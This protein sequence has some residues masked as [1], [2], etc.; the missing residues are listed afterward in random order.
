MWFANLRIVL[1][2]RTIERGALEIRD[3][4][5][6]AIV[7][8]YQN[9]DIDGAGLT[10]IPGIIDL[11]G[12]MIERDM[13]P[14][15][16]VL[17]PIE[18]ALFELDKRLAGNG[19]TTA[20][21]AIS[22]LERA[23]RIAPSVRSIDRAEQIILTIRNLRACLLTDFRVH[24]RFEV[25]CPRA[26]PTVI[27][28]IRRGHV[29]FVSL[30]DHTPGQGQYRD[31]TKYAEVIEKWRRVS[32][33]EAEQMSLDRIRR[34]EEN[35]AS[36]EDARPVAQAALDHHLLVASHDDDT[37]SKVLT[38]AQL[39]VTLC[40]FPVTIEAARQA[41][42]I[43]MLVAMGAPNI[44]LGCSHTGNLSAREAIDAGLVDVLVADYYPA[45]LLQAAF[46]LARD[47]AMPLHQ[48]IRLITENPA[49]ALHLEGRGRLAVGAVAD[50]A[51]VE[52]G[53]LP[54]VRGT[55]RAGVPTYWDGTM[56][57][58]E[59][60]AGWRRSLVESARR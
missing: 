19:I 46:A 48:A 29:G 34:S 54:R 5:I 52:D 39:G 12:D 55:L 42:E 28:L 35:R 13:E 36:W 17:F 50:I 49:R 26:I 56:V 20:Y 47:G 21:A 33:E 7:E 58:R 8:G 45:A 1:P 3:G 38:M 53:A 18:L 27:D 24:L 43:G 11:H 60:S 10:A 59:R 4:R 2:D 22:F 14:R 25:T 15:P 37:P 16:G 9:G 41:R 32:K 40:E 30:M 23:D 57:S 44:L 31:L 6:S 51:F